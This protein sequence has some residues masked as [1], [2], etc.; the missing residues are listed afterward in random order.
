MDSRTSLRTQWIQRCFGLPC[1]PCVV[2]S[3]AEGVKA[4]LGTRCSSPSRGSSSSSSASLSSTSPSS[5]S[6]CLLSSSTSPTRLATL[7]PY[8]PSLRSVELELTTRAGPGREAKMGDWNGRVRNAGIDGRA[9]REYR[10]GV[11]A[12][13]V[14]ED[15]YLSVGCCYLEAGAFAGT[16]IR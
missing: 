12:E 3:F 7:T 11:G 5:P 2:L 13:R 16:R 15:V 1:T 9:R 10:W 14:W 4:D 8:V 6:S